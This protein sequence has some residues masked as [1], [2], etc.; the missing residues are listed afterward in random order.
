MLPALALTGVTIVVVPLLAL[1]SNLKDYYVK[2][3]IKCVK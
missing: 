1:K 2:A 3:G